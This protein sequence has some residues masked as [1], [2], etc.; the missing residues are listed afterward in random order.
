[1]LTFDLHGDYIKSYFAKNREASCEVI[2][3][4]GT[5]LPSA[6]IERTFIWILQPGE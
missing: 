3:L 1:M 2:I 5:V 4:T 6:S